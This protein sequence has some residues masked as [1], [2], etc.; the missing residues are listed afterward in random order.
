[1]AGFR[2]VVVQGLIKLDAI[3]VAVTLLVTVTGVVPTYPAGRVAEAV[4][5]IAA[6]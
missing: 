6:V 3:R 4:I 2:I 1:M 5:V